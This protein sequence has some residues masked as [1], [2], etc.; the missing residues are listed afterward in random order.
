MNLEPNATNPRRLA[1]FIATV[2]LIMVAAVFAVWI[3][4]YRAI[5]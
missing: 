5:R 3:V 4:N 1:L 2:L